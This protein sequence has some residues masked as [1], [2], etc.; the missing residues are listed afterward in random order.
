MT[1]IVQHHVSRV[2]P[3]LI[4]LAIWDHVTN[5]QPVLLTTTKQVLHHVR[6]VRPGLTKIAPPRLAGACL[7]RR[8]Q[9]PP[10]LVHTVVICAIVAQ[11]PKIVIHA[12]L[13][14]LVR[15]TMTRIPRQPALNV[16]LAQPH[17]MLARLNVL[18]ADPVCLVTWG[19]PRARL[20]KQGS[21]QTV[22][23]A[24]IVPTARLEHH[25]T[26][27]RCVPNAN[28]VIPII[29]RVRLE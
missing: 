14:Y 1:E 5:A 26:T 23:R 28:L 29:T 18:D 4:R 16:Q 15:M 12:P 3:V 10:T 24:H 7:A 17:S 20:V 9:S 21:F 6:F 2:P 19:L 13:V 25:L 22:G 27:K 8:V 11:A